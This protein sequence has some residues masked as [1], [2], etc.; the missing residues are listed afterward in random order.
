MGH[1]Q[2]TSADLPE[3]RE[4]MH[5]GVRTSLTLKCA[6]D[7]RSIKKMCTITSDYNELYVAEG[8]NTFWAC[9]FDA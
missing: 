8:L 1:F 6:G 9:L 7:S 2:F 4:E 5:G 3:L